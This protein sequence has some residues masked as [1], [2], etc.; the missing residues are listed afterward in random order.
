MP[1]VWS[2]FSRVVT[3]TPRSLELQNCSLAEP[4]IVEAIGRPVLTESEVGRLEIQDPPWRLLRMYSGPADRLTQP[5][6]GLFQG[7]LK[8]RESS[9]S[10]DR[11]RAIRERGGGKR[12]SC[13]RMR[14]RSAYFLAGRFASDE[15]SSPADLS[16][17]RPTYSTSSGL[18]KIVA[19][20]FARFK[21][22]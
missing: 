21:T 12:S 17:L 11:P 14:L 8:S 18:W 15:R 16:T 1:L 10:A 5:S 9:R 13:E 19:R 7:I 20:R 3:G 6:H 4:E 22:W 2:W